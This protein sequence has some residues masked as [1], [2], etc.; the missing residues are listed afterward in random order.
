[1][2]TTNPDVERLLAYFHHMR[3]EMLVCLHEQPR[4][5]DSSCQQA[6]DAIPMPGWTEM[7]M[8]QL[9]TINDCIARL[10]QERMR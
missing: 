2:S 4:I 3:E 10:E 9:T 7:V 5:Y 1:M 6:S 8:D